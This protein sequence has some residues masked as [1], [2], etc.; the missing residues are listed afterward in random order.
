MTGSFSTWLA[1]LSREELAGLLTERPD[2]LAD[3]EPLTLGELAERLSGPRGVMAA[4]ATCDLPLVQFAEVLAAL[5]GTAARADAEALLGAAPDDFERVLDELVRRGLVWPADGLLHLVEPLREWPIGGGP[6]GLGP[7]AAVLLPHLRV[8]DLRRIVRG[9]GV[10][11]P[12]KRKAE[13]LDAALAGLGDAERVRRVVAAAPQRERRRIEKIAHA[14]CVEDYQGIHLFGQE[15]PYAWA[16]A[17]G[18]LVQPDW[19][20]P[21]MPAEVALALRGPS[22]QAS[23]TPAAPSVGTTAAPEGTVTAEFAAASARAVE[24]MEAVLRSCTAEPPT[25]LKSGGV[26]VRELRRMARR[27]GGSEDAVRLWLE[28]AAAE[29]LL[30]WRDG[31]LV[32]TA[33]GGDPMPAATRLASMLRTW[34]RMP[35]LPTLDHPEEGRRTPLDTRAYDPAAPRLRAAVLESLADLPGGHGA[36]GPERLVAAVTWRSPLLF[37]DAEL[38]PPYI[39][40]VWREAELLGVLAQG[41]LTPTGRVLVGADAP[42]TLDEAVADALEA[43]CGQVLLQSDLTAVVPGPPAPWLAGLLDLVADRESRGIASVWRFSMA[44]V[45]RALDEGRSAEG[46]RSDLEAAAGTDLPQP[47]AYL[48]DDVARRH[49]EITVT[50]FA[51]AICCSRPAL[52]A[53]ILAHRGLRRLKLRELAPT[54]LASA[55]PVNHTLVALRAAG[56]VPVGAG[57]GSAPFIERAPARPSHRRKR[58]ARKDE[59]SRP[60][61]PIDLAARLHGTPPDPPAEADVVEA[62]MGDHAPHLSVAERRMLVHAV[63]TGTAVGIDYVNGEG[64]PTTRVIEKIR[65]DAPFLTAWCRL[66]DDERVFHIGRV[67]A[68]TPA[69]LMT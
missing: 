20:E 51:C 49:G 9:L 60:R 46:I 57:D 34:E 64:N 65:L 31:A 30:D 21:L 68:V 69:V 47:L 15:S 17:R 5:G 16:L 45:R 7:S 2:A 43:T 44:S 58:S 14:G 28:L 4:F 24:Q 25:R 23:F 62:R 19:M 66:R 18:L 8:E 11:S 48:I 56:Y 55:E 3:P 38:A 61:T 10:E 59:A 12:G 27:T 6:L 50:A 53:E 36:A 29:G 35:R 41:V 67:Q 54:V 40:A 22:Y 26:G 42:A 37:E 1:G 32:P 63:Q 39:A 33:E 52:L 13:L